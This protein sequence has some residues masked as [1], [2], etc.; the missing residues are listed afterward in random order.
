MMLQQEWFGIMKGAFIRL[1]NSIRAVI[2]CLCVQKKSLSLL[3]SCTI[4][5]AD[6]EWN[7]CDCC[8]ELILIKNAGAGQV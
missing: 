4:L 2:A 1:N 8:N 5:F 6:L 3:F 7:C